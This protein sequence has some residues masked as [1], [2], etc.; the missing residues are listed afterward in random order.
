MHKIGF[1]AKPINLVF[2]AQLLVVFFVAFGVISRVWILPLSAIV[3]IFILWSDL[4]TSTAFFVRSI[5]IFV[6]IPFTSYFDSFNLW[7]IA[8][9]LIFLKWFFVNYK[10]PAEWL[11]SLFSKKH[12]FALFYLLFF[13]TALASLFVASDFIAAVK[14]IIY[15]VNLSLIGF[16]IYD[17]IKK[18]LGFSR[19]LFKNILIAGVIIVAVGVAQLITAYL[20]DIFAFIKFWGETIQLGFYGQQWAQTAIEANTWFAYYGHQLS[21]RVFSTFP[22]SHS[23]PVFVLMTLP[24]LLAL[25][26]TK[27]FSAAQVSLG[28]ALRT[29]ASFLIAL[30]PIFYFL[31]ILSGTRGIWLAA[32]G[33]VLVLPFSLKWLH[34]ASAKVMIKY[35]TLTLALF[36]LLFPLAYPIFGSNQ[37]QVAKSDS[38]ILA[39]RLRSIL[40]ASET[41]NHDRLEIWKKTLS[42]IARHPILG[43]G[44][45]NF[46]VVL[47]QATEYAKAGSSAHNLYLHV[48]A[49]VGIFG[50]LTVLGMLW[51]IIKRGLAVVDFSPDSV[52]KIYA[53]GFLVFAVWVLLYNLTDAILFD[54]RA[55]L[56]FTV[57]V[58]VILGL[59]RQKEKPEAG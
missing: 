57:N 8:S 31:I 17:L 16:V 11:W 26:L 54:E 24:A 27:I 38:Q 36:I 9:G 29:R 56:I 20:A 23:F 30:L 19:I 51:L 45:G 22:D 50:L 48:A 28:K 10:K 14:R 3:A 12:Y 53:A 43:V 1:L 5:P 25:S 59:H 2:L 52:T 18:N 40:D 6:A 49:E 7:R 39:K 47:A 44:I 42:S 33:P 46:P 32:I 55:F 4:E 34:S 15:L 35:V 41:S 37:F 58:A 21:L 13:L